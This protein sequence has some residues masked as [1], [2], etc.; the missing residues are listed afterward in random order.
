MAGYEKDYEDLLRLF[1]RHK[2]KYCLDA[3]MNTVCHISM[4]PDPETAKAAVALLKASGIKASIDAKGVGR[5]GLCGPPGV[6]VLYRDREKADTP[7][8]Q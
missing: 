5:P 2:V 7:D 6:W 4:G 3:S 1:N 8:H